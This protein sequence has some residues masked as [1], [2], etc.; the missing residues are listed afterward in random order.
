MLQQPILEIKINLFDY[1]FD[2]LTCII[3]MLLLKLLQI[4]K[5]Y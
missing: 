5:T 3:I 2:C 4:V 1:L